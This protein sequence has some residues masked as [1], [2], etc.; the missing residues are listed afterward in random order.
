MWICSQI[1]I[2]RS[3]SITSN[4][5]RIYS[6]EHAIHYQFVVHV[7]EDNKHSGTRAF[8]SP[9]TLSVLGEFIVSCGQGR[10][11]SR[12]HKN[13]PSKTVH[14]LQLAQIIRLKRVVVVVPLKR[15]WKGWWWTSNAIRR[16]YYYCVHVL[17]Y[18]CVGVCY[19]LVSLIK[20]FSVQA[21]FSNPSSSS[22]IEVV[23]HPPLYVV[24]C[25]RQRVLQSHQ[26]N[27]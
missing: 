8:F 9:N 21:A 15:G 14:V 27:V 10:S 26:K 20:G 13:T 24:I 23:R 4:V 1:N 2:Y 25:C 16:T 5:H 17:L 3:R 6:T 7:N 22:R 18:L 11:S 12:H 19:S